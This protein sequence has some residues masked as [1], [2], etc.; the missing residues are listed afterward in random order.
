LIAEPLPCAIQLHWKLGSGLSLIQLAN[1]L[2]DHNKAAAKIRACADQC[3][4][5]ITRCRLLGVKQP[6]S[7]VL[8]VLLQHTAQQVSEMTD[9]SLA[10]SYL[11]NAGLT[12]LQPVLESFKS[13]TSLS[14]ADSGLRNSAV[15]TLALSV[16]A[17][18]QLHT[19]DLGDNMLSAPAGA[20][21]LSLA[22]RC[23]HLTDIKV[24]GNPIDQAVPLS[25]RLNGPTAPQD[26]LPRGGAGGAVWVRGGD[27]PLSLQLALALNGNRLRKLD[28]IAERGSPSTV[29][30][31]ER[32]LQLLR[33]VDDAVNAVEG[34]RPRTLVSPDAADLCAVQQRQFEG[35]GFTKD[36]MTVE[37]AM[38]VLEKA[39]EVANS[40][41]F[42]AAQTELELQESVWDSDDRAARELLDTAV[43]EVS[44]DWKM[45]SPVHEAASAVHGL[46]TDMAAAAKALRE[47]TVPVNMDRPVEAFQRWQHATALQ[48]SA[49]Q[50]KQLVQQ[51]DERTAGGRTASASVGSWGWC[52]SSDAASIA[53][54]DKTVR[55]DLEATDT[56]R[57]AAGMC[58]ADVLRVSQLF[59][60]LKTYKEATGLAVVQELEKVDGCGQVFRGA[61][62]GLGNYGEHSHLWKN[63]VAEGESYTGSL[64]CAQFVKFMGVLRQGPAE[65]YDKVITDLEAHTGKHWAPARITLNKATTAGRAVWMLMRA[66]RVDFVLEP[67]EEALPTVNVQLAGSEADQEPVPSS[68]VAAL[69]L[70]AQAVGPGWDCSQAAGKTALEAV[71]SVFAPGLERWGICKTVLEQAAQYSEP[72]ADIKAKMHEMETLLTPRNEKFQFVEGAAIG[73]ADVALSTHVAA[74]TA[75]G[76]RIWKEYPAVWRH[77]CAVRDAMNKMHAGAGHWKCTGSV[78]ESRRGGSLCSLLRSRIEQLSNHPALNRLEIERNRIASELPKSL[79][80]RWML[81]PT[82]DASTGQLRLHAG[83][84]FD[85]IIVT[86][87]RDGLPSTFTAQ[88]GRWVLRMPDTA[89]AHPTVELH[90]LRWV[91][92]G[93]NGD[94]QRDDAVPR[95]LMAAEGTELSTVKFPV[96]IRGQLWTIERHEPALPLQL[97]EDL[98]SIFECLDKDENGN[99]TH[100]ELGRIYKGNKYL[101][102]FDADGNGTV[103]MEEFLDKARKILERNGATALDRYVRHLRTSK[104]VAPRFREI[105]ITKKSA[106]IHEGLDR[107]RSGTLDREELREFD[108]RGRIFDQLDQDENGDVTVEELTKYFVQTK[109][110]REMIDGFIDHLDATVRPR[111]PPPKADL[112]SRTPIF[113]SDFNLMPASSK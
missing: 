89:D 100:E 8:Q 63:V 15:E 98:Q 35:Y 79:L 65:T 23:K 72:A 82:Y 33:G 50:M 55:K 95:G 99:L 78:W 10:R 58:A 71:E 20:M 17:L 108:H 14:F 59:R 85:R 40:A 34:M 80:G 18:L 5:Y 47:Q 74:M 45:V 2:P 4:S 86:P 84:K 111:L 70:V 109:K 19:L 6:N 68:C 28:E 75:G 110:S 30:D 22:R 83:S 27:T 46:W 13:I 107:D 90:V 105:S 87:E 61:G 49:A 53:Q 44:T 7:R 73:I 64:C 69:K 67:L 66:L 24:P 36:W 92:R 81:S 16:P 56:P 113:S 60:A 31:C 32:L 1:G 21:L 54:L 39:Q 57:E 11:G 12:A 97:F 62:D 77:L 51:S 9:L 104:A 76:W 94:I 38:Q 29:G 25:H 42:S 3:K 106:R 48:Q 112:L 93:A 96:Q 88:A 43:E 103:E 52:E 91:V 101:T 26:A 41:A 37:G 102:Q